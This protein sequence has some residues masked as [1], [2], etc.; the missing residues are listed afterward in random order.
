MSGRVLGLIGIVLV[1]LY[2]QGYIG[3]G[4]KQG[5]VI[6]PQTATAEPPKII[7]QDDGCSDTKLTALTTNVFNFLNTSLSDNFDVTLRLYSGASEQFMLS[8]TDTTAPSST[9]VRCLTDI[10]GKILSTD[11][12]AGDNAAIHS[13]TIDLGSVTTS[14]DM[15]SI[16]FKTQGSSQSLSIQ[17]EKHGVLNFRAYDENL[18][19]LVFNS[20]ETNRNDFDTTG[21]NYTSTTDNA[22][23]QAIGIGETLKMTLEVQSTT[24][25]TDFFDLGGYLCLDHSATTWDT[26]KIVLDGAELSDYKLGG[27]TP[28]ETKLFSN[29]DECFY[30]PPT[31]DYT[32]KNTA[33]FYLEVRA[34]TEPAIASGDSDS[35][36][37]Y[38]YSRGHYADTF[39]S[40]ILR[41]GAATNAPNPAA[42][43]TR[44]T[45]QISVS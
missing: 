38:F 4:S 25:Y 28:Y 2:M 29:W 27:L 6:Q 44:Q 42:V 31:E 16:M 15:T 9:N 26:P 11:A 37:G 36:Y 35:I 7:L 32:T 23:Y 18:K 39:D 33:K 19:G 10:K 40:N 30:V 45:F 8:I 1:V 43:F 34:N 14:P 13:A 5:V 3:G 20:G 12:D 22:T 24:P 21:V 17:G 41:V